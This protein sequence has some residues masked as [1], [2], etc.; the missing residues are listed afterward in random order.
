MP[1]FVTTTILL[2]HLPALNVLTHEAKL[3]AKVGVVPAFGSAVLHQKLPQT[4]TALL[5][6]TQRF[7]RRLRK[8]KLTPVSSKRQCRLNCRP[9]FSASEVLTASQNGRHPP[10]TA[11]ANS[12]NKTK[13]RNPAIRYK[14]PFQRLV[15]RMECRSSAAQRRTPLQ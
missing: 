9:I 6:P 3:I 15:P 5:A 11:A 7:K 4:P 2:V 8:S 12:S 13:I 14:P 1:S 10:D